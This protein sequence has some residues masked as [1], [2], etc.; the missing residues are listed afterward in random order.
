MTRTD[1]PTKDY[2]GEMRRCSKCKKRKDKS[3]FSKLGDGL[4][5]WCKKCHLAKIRAYRQ[6]EKEAKIFKIQKEHREQQAL[7]KEILSLPFFKYKNEYTT[8]L[9][10]PIRRQGVADV[11]FKA[12]I[13][14]NFNE[15]ESMGIEMP[16]DWMELLRDWSDVKLKEKE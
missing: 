13:L 16:A 12:Q 3:K 2:L 9:V 8:L 11:Q 6:K 7:R 14:N 5:Y 4:Q 10:E 15:D 1:M